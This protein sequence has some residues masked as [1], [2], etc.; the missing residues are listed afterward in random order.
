MVFLR[1]LRKVTDP[2]CNSAQQLGRADSGPINVAVFDEVT[3]T[4]FITCNLVDVYKCMM[5]MMM[6]MMVN[7][8]CA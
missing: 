6:M 2:P 8:V 5:M 7:H 4:R 3:E 1:N